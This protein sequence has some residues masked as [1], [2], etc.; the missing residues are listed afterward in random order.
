MKKIHLP[1]LTRILFFGLVVSLYTACSNKKEKQLS[2]IPNDAA[3]VVAANVKSM[4]VKSLELKDILNI[5]K[6][7]DQKDSLKNLIKNSGIDFMS[8]IYVFGNADKDQS[9]MYVAVVALLSD[10]KKFEQTL[11]DNIKDVQIKEE[12]GLKYLIQDK[13]SLGWKND[14]ALAVFSQSSGDAA[15]AK[16]VELFNTKEENTLAKQNTKFNEFINQKNDILAW[17]NYEKINDI[18]I[19]G[20]PYSSILKDASLKDTYLG[21]NVDF[22]KGKIVGGVQT[23]YNKETFDK[24]KALNKASISSDVVKEHPGGDVIAILGLAFNTEALVAMLK[25]MGLTSGVD[26]NMA[27]MLGSEYNVDYLASALSGDFVATVNKVNIGDVSKYNFETG[28][29]STEKGVKN[30]DYAIS[31]GIKDQSKINKLLEVM[32]QKQMLSK[33]GNTY[34]LMDQAWL[35]LNDKSL[36]MIGGSKEYTDA[37]TQGKKNNLNSELSS[38]LTSNM[39]VLKL[40]LSK[41]SAEAK[42]YTEK[43]LKPVYSVG[44][45]GF[46]IYAEEM[47]NQISTSKFQIDFA[48]KDQNSLIT[49]QQQLKEIPVHP[50]FPLSG[51]PGISPMADE[52][53]VAEPSEKKEEVLQ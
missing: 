19:E 30:A 48:N 32:A 7:D 6:V 35:V 9:K 46:S 24:Y 40:D 29:M 13:M 42:Q 33:N 25:E 26:Q 37:V 28:Q 16:L 41:L 49:I 22:E 4:A 36:I 12:S 3:Y 31:L 38:A 39:M 44:L 5:L 20:N 10:T 43:D 8:S 18:S 17:V 50:A 53:Q 27:A 11:K 2:T 45:D 1:N 15:K 51:S 47:K 23:F 21:I 14:L 34:S 52:Q